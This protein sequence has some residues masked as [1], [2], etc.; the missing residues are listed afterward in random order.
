[1]KRFQTLMASIT[2]EH[3]W[4]IAVMVGIFV[5]LNTHPIRPHDFWW[6]IAIGRDIVNSGKIPQLDTY[7][8][9]QPGAP[10]LF[11]DQFWLM[12][13]ALYKLYQAGGAILVVL[14]HTLMIIPAYFLLMLL[15]WRLT[16][17]LRATAFGVLFAATLGFGNWNVRPQAIS[18][19]LGVLVL[20]GIS[21]YRRTHRWQWLLIF[22][23]VMALWVNCHGSFPIGPALVGLLLADE[24]WKVI[25]Q[26][27]KQRR[28]SFQN[29]LPAL[30]GFILALGGCLV[31]PRGMGFVSYLST[32]A[33]NSVV[34]NLVVEWMPPNF[35]SW[36]GILF[37]VIFTLVV[38]L[39]VLSP[40]RPSFYQIATFLVFGILSLNYYRGIIWFGIVMAPVVADHLT[41]L[42]D[43]AGIK[44]APMP[45]GQTRS[46]NRIFVIALLVLA[47]ISL[48]WFKQYWPVVPEKAGLISA[49]T[50]IRATQYL[51]DHHLPAQ[52]FHYMPFGSY[53]MWAAQP[54]YKV[55][56]DSRIELY[57]IN[58]WN[59]Y[60]LISAGGS[61]WEA[62]LDQYKIST[63]LLEP[64]VQLGLIQAAS[65]S[66]HWQEVYRDSQAVIFIRR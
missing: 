63:L 60:L 56:V 2:I 9:T 61:D 15:S 33:S 1:L 17:N 12:E 59:D 45:T 7:S 58:V 42:M 41:A 65:V 35:I 53:M 50:P 25:K 49:E 8:Y 11:Y 29:W 62:K 10:Y 21:E 55:F 18:Y 31:N 52:V 48:P 20:L 13:I 30:A 26:W 3:L 57:P 40:R 4:A 54:Q 37:Y 28:Y 66:S 16:H 36:E 19:L 24:S 46:L 6:H 44:P 14:A 38:V 27:Y 23:F 5:F 34:Q 47:F 51:L 43:K 39:L 64:M 22:P 32:M